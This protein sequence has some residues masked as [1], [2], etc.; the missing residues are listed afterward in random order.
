MA[1]FVWEMGIDWQAMQAINGLSYLRTGLACQGAMT[2]ASMQEHDTITFRIFDVSA[3]AD[4][5]EVAA[6]SSFLITTAP[7]IPSSAT[8]GIPLNILE[9]TF[10][11]DEKTFTSTAFQN[12]HRSWTSQA[13]PIPVTV[14]VP[15]GRFLLGFQT[16]ALGVDGTSRTFFHDPEMIVGEHG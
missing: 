1:E 4:G 6:I 8:A 3:A 7:A 11:Q 15:A 14:K 9:P 12:P 2:R 5:P 10:Q 16:Q 13:S